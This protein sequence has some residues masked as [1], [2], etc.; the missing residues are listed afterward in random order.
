MI[1]I[2]PAKESQ[3][4]E[5][6][7]IVRECAQQLLDKGVKY[8][9]NSHGDYANI[10]CDIANQYVYIIF[11]KKVP[12]GTITLKPDETV[13]NALFMDRLAI[14]PHYQRR[15]LA[16]T[17]IDFAISEAIVQGFQIIRGT[18]PVDDRSLCQMLED[19]GFQNRGIVT[20]VPNEMVKILFEKSLL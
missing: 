4:L 20:H 2:K 14:F 13:E 12:A 17:M 3:L 11:F 7:Y 16:K 5:V 18:I 8:W 9:H 6:L 1:E 10:S 15:G 19:K